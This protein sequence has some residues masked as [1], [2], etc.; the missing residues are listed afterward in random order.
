MSE[1]TL[2]E[3]LPNLLTSLSECDYIE[4][5]FYVVHILL[6]CC[7]PIKT[8]TFSAFVPYGL[9]HTRFIIVRI[10]VCSI[11]EVLKIQHVL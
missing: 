3:Y 5:A 6:G 9:M 7:N 1:E 2:K 4:I 10:C 8:L 11:V